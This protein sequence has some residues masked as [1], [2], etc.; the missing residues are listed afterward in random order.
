LV[1]ERPEIFLSPSERAASF[2]KDRPIALCTHASATE[3]RWPL[4]KWQ[5]LADLLMRKGCR[6]VEV[7]RHDLPPLSGVKNLRILG[8]RHVAAVLAS[9]SLFVGTDSGLVHVAAAVGTP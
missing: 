6:V 4:A 2:V 5:R 1:D 7:G 3:R 9:C 8:L